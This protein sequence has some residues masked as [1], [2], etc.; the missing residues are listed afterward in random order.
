MQSYHLGYRAD[1][2]GEPLA[3]GLAYFYLSGTTTLKSVYSDAD[4]VT[5]LSNPV[6]ANSAGFFPELVYLDTTAT[7]R[8]VIKDETG[9]TISAYSADPI[10]TS[11][12]TGDIDG[13]DI[14][15]GTIPST[16]LAPGSVVAHLGYTPANETALNTQQVITVALT[17]MVA[18][19]AMSTAPTGWLECAGQ[20]VLR[21]DYAALFTA[22]GTTW[23]SVDATHFTL[24]D[25]R[26][27]FIRGW[28]HG[29]GTD[30]GRAFASSQTD[31]FEAHTH[32]V[33]GGN[34]GASST[35]ITTQSNTASPG[36]TTS[37]AGGAAET[38]PR[39]FALLYCI[40]T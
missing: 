30:S 20:S 29:K 17:G 19:F 4:A 28:D 23:G 3:N 27:E 13:A 8:V 33:T 12:G 7:Y 40:K 18:A 1:T 34:N 10:N 16:A 22:I 21:A 31:E 6:V 9:N 36:V 35:Y 39:N 32:T 5:P 11:A 38:R 26:G 15:D 37:S 2:D 14:S 25:L 24:P